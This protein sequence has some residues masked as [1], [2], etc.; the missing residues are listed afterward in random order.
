[1]T[2]DRP[3]SQWLARALDY[4]NGEDGDALLAIDMTCGGGA[5]TRAL[6]AR[7]WRVLAVDL[8]PNAREL[9]VER[10]DADQQGRL[11]V[12]IG[13]F[14]RVDLPAADLVFAQMSLPLPTTRSRRPWMPHL[15]PW[16]Q[17]EASPGTSSASA[18]SGSSTDPL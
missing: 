2:A 9:L 18:T 7:G 10:V 16:P 12:A 8:T 3:P 4:A 15:V 14:D 5:V 13:G 17:A 1:M 11:E 6:L